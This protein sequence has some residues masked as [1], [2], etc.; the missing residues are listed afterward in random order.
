MY[1]TTQ[2]IKAFDTLCHY[3]QK[4]IYQLVGGTK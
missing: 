3:V 2:A 1:S 4:T